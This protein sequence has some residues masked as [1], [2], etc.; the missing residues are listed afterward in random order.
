MEL[1]NIPPDLETKLKD[2][3]MELNGKGEVKKVTVLFV[4]I[5]NFTGLFQKHDSSTVLAIMDLYF[6]VLMSI[7]KKYDGI[8]PMISG[9]SLMAVWGLPL[10]QRSDAYN[11]ARAAID[12]RMEMFHLV[13]EL[14]RVGTVPL[15]IGIGIGSGKVVSGFV[16]PSSRRDFTLVG[17]CIIRGQRL[18]SIASDNRI[19][20]DKITASEV[21]SLSY[22]LPIKKTMVK[23][24][25]KDIDAYE[26]EGI[27]EFNR[28]FESVRRH[29]RFL[30]AKVIGIKKV[31]PQKRKAGMLKSIGEGGLGI[32]LHDH[33]DFELKIGD[34][35]VIDAK[36]LNLLGMEEVKGVV[37]RKEEHKADG[38]FRMKT[39]DVGIKLLELPEETKKRL[40][41]LAVGKRVM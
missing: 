3:G 8:I 10:E 39:W 1:L 19:F 20:I 36:G 14:V 13:P 22:L 24:G 6:R 17:N 5:K 29:P 30:V 23:L 37:V 4:D 18:E 9:G 12:M 40:Q 32:E 28:Q 2:E 31:S 25:I 34:K 38:I 33:K 27:Y 26:I 41:K 15:E 11:A 7:V 35:T 21:K 16:G